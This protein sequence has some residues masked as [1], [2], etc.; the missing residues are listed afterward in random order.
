MRVRRIA[1]LIDGGF[2]LK[3]LP[4]LVRAEHR[5][6]PEKVARLI[7][8]LSRNHVLHLT[9]ADKSAWHD[10]VYRIFYY[11]A[12]PYDGQA[13]HPLKN[14][15]IDFGK[16]PEAQFRLGLFECLRRQ[17]K[18]ALRLGKVT[19][20]GDWSPPSEKTRRLLATRN[21]ISGLDF[22]P[23]AN[24]GQLTLTPPQV[25]EAVRLQKKW[26]EISDDGILLGLR[27]KGVDM[28]IGVDIAS[29]TL[30]KQADTIILVS[31]DSDFVPASKLARREGVEFVLDPLWQSVNADLFEHIDGLHSGLQ[32]PKNTGAVVAAAAD[33]EHD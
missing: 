30:K 12:A 25:Q 3:R 23:L 15:Q 22:A 6:S 27:Q 33:E 19:R 18:V 16:T 29:I 21:W 11:D 5:D 7:S 1:V 2:F 14:L 31:G 13:H 26:A 4:K 24:G 32:R 17:R 9:R 20:E 10:H 28:R 8:L